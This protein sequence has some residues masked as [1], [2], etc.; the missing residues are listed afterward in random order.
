MDFQSESPCDLEP[1]SV[2]G[3]EATTCGYHVKGKGNK[4]FG[5]DNGV[6]LTTSLTTSL[7]SLITAL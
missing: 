2:G 5:L 3:E 1:L 7:T 4:T 6:G